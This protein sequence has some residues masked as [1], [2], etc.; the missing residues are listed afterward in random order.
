MTCDFH[1]PKISW[2]SLTAP[3]TR[4]VFILKEH[5]VEYTQQVTTPTKPGNVLDPNFTHYI[6]DV[7]IFVLKPLP[8]IHRMLFKCSL[9]FP[10][11]FPPPI[12]TEHTVSYPFMS[13]RSDKSSDGVQT[14]D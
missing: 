6:P 4:V 7:K 5:A 8:G 13:T 11:N 12:H 2:S 9:G 14:L 3:L 10:N 1:V